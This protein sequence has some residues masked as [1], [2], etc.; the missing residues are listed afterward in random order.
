MFFNTGKRPGQVTH[1]GIYMGKGSMLH[2]P[3]PG[4]KVQYASVADRSWFR[5]RLLGIRRVGKQTY[6]LAR[7][8]VG[9][10]V[11][12]LPS[13]MSVLVDRIKADKVLQTASL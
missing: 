3:R 11:G 13:D 12:A 8:P 6:A 10:E 2:A 7:Q 5:P 4:K 9:W 1:V